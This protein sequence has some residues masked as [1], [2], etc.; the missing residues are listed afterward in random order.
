M[1]NIM[2][3]IDANSG[4]HNLKLDKQ[5]SYLTTVFVSFWKVLVQAIAILEQHW[6]VICFNGK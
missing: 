5:S 1:C 6:Q 4:Y 2:S 3:I